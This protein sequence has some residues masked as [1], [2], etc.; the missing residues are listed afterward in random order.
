MQSERVLK[1]IECIKK[2]MKSWYIWV[3][4]IRSVLHLLTAY[5]SVVNI[6]PM[7]EVL[8]AFFVS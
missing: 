2:Q 8:Y 7:I 4:V 5:R 3:E 1:Q 6:S